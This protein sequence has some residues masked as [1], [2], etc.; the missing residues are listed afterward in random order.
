M[1]SCFKR[2]SDK[3]YNVHKKTNR[4]KHNGPIE[5]QKHTRGNSTAIC[6]NCFYVFAQMLHI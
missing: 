5:M 1:E 3:Q 2:Y 6:K 4:Y